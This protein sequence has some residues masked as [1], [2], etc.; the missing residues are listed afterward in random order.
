M[1]VRISFASIVIT[2]E[3]Q[4]VDFYTNRLGF[5][6]VADF[7][8]PFGSRFLMFAPPGGGARIVATKAVPGVEWKAGVFTNIAFEAEDVQATY[9]SLRARGVQ[10]I[11]APER[12]PWGGLQ[13]RFAD[14]DGNI[15]QLNSAGGWSR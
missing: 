9:E 7:P 14:Q 15:F 8:T 11:Q 4:A 1:T 10:F 6:L 12:Q 13:A 5:Q 2:N 3:E